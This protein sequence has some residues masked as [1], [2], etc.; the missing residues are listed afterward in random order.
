MAAI[1]RTT[2]STVISHGRERFFV[3][4]PHTTPIIFIDEINN[5]NVLPPRHYS[6]WR[7]LNHVTIRTHARN[8]FRLNSS[9]SLMSRFQ[10]ATWKMVNWNTAATW[11]SCDK[12]R[13][14]FHN[15]VGVCAREGHTSYS[16]RVHS[17]QWRAAAARAASSQCVPSSWANAA[18][19]VGRARWDLIVWKYARF[20]SSFFF[21]FVPIDWVGVVRVRTIYFQSNFCLIAHS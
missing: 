5:N 19:S 17:R 15:G 13:Y 10:E 16:Q 7:C 4:R 9:V 14:P 20:S 11:C 3:S 21:F 18:G 6:C 1:A 2:Q 8:R 12:T